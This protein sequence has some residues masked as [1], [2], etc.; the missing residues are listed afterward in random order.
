MTE[1]S[2]RY[3]SQTILRSSA[4][5]RFAFPHRNLKHEFTILLRDTLYRHKL[6]VTSVFLLVLMWQDTALTVINF[7]FI[8]T[9]IPA[10]VRNFRLKDVKSQ[11]FYTYGSTAI[12]L[13]VMS[14]IFFTLEFL[15]TT[16]STCG[17]AITWYILTYQKISN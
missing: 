1:H 11:S 4:I 12:L 13:T 10:I 15:L 16:L 2:M 6:Y 3:L 7:L 8:L 5:D 17:T 14:F 9:L